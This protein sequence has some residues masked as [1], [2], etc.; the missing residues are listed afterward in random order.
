MYCTLYIHSRF[1]SNFDL[2]QLMRQ[3]MASGILAAK[4]AAKLVANFVHLP[5][6]VGMILYCGI[7]RAF[8]T[9]VCCIP[10]QTKACG[11]K[12]AELFLR[13]GRSCVIIENEFVLINTQ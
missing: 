1:S 7:T 6:D 3:L 2:H 9:D 4:C 5:C 10:K 12:V 13:T 11:S 8:A